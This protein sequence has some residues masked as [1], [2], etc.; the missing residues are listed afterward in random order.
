MFWEAASRH[1]IKRAA[2]PA[3]KQNDLF[4]W[5]DREDG[6]TIESKSA[7]LLQTAP[8]E[9]GRSRAEQLTK[10]PAGVG[11]RRV[12]SAGRS[13][14][15]AKQHRTVAGEA[16]ARLLEVNRSV[17]GVQDA[18]AIE[19]PRSRFSARIDLWKGRPIGT[20]FVMGN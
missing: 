2:G 10:A 17:N 20:P 19:L 11:V 15:Y 13:S 7:P 8:A 16:I 14:M 12:R 9:G 4:G 18:Q 3:V 6:S 1:A 5:L